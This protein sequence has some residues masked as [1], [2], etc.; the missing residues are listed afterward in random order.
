MTSDAD[1]YARVAEGFTSR[2][3][4]VREDQ[5]S[6]P[7]P[8]DGWAARDV[9]AHVIRTHRA[10]LARLEGSE[11]PDP[12]PDADLVADWHAARDAVTQALADPS[13]SATVLGGMFG[14]QTFASMVGRMVCTDTLVHTWD[15]AR[16]GGLD[17]TLDPEAMAA[18]M[19]FL[20]PMSDAIR[21]PGGFAPPLPAAEDA[22]PQ[23]A[24]L[25]FCGRE[26]NP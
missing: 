9:A 6:S 18:G 4:A 17:E 15:L 24:F 11:P 25:S 20:G 2:I 8:C 23:T 1:R 13:A 7:S 19:A 26:V 12:D 21:G 16:A 22:D 14:D 5:W 3:E 10:V